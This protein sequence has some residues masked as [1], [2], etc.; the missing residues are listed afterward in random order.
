MLADFLI[1]DIKLFKRHRI[2]KLKKMYAAKRVKKMLSYMK[3]DDRNKITEPLKSQKR[4]YVSNFPGIFYVVYKDYV[5]HFRTRDAIFSTGVSLQPFLNLTEHLF[6]KISDI[7]VE[8]A[9]T[10]NKF[11]H[12][13]LAWYHY[14]GHVLNRNTGTDTDQVVTDL[15]LEIQQQ[16]KE[17]KEM[18]VRV[19]LSC[20]MKAFIDYFLKLPLELKPK[21]KQNKTQVYVRINFDNTSLYKIEGSLTRQMI[22]KRKSPKYTKILSATKVTII[23]QEIDILKAMCFS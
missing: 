20:V 22:K 14:T 19:F 2:E 11:A 15:L 10:T 8:K 13:Q 9:K 4:R 7:F 5:K 23:N 3:T 12:L 21:D 18:D 17:A 6:D 1:L 16:C